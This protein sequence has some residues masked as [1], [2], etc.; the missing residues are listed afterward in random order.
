MHAQF[1]A[2]QAE[3]RAAYSAALLDRFTAAGKQ[4]AA[5]ARIF[6]E[7]VVKKDFD[8]LRAAVTEWRAINDLDV[9]TAE[10]IASEPRR[11][12]TNAD[13]RF[14][15]LYRVPGRFGGSI[16][17]QERPPG[18]GSADALTLRQRRDAASTRLAGYMR[19]MPDTEEAAVFEGLFKLE[20]SISKEFER[21]QCDIGV[22]CRQGLE[23]SAYKE[24]KLKERFDESVQQFNEKFVAPMRNM[25]MILASLTES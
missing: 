14:F 25:H 10:F 16:T 11:H 8:G 18:S 19:D 23:S 7:A 4:R 22:Q 3:Q 9:A 13:R 6:G 2:A 20:Y 17:Y 15:D 12:L 1:Q 5:Y 21:F 24:Y